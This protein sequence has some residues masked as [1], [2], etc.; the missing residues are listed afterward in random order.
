ML[1]AGQYKDK[2]VKLIVRKKSNPKEF[3]KYVDKL[4]DAGVFDLKVLR[5]FHSMRVKNLIL[6]NQ[7]IPSILSRYLDESETDIDKNAV[8]EI[9][10]NIY[11]EACEVV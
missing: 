7:K 8:K 4:M 1:D 11:K 9:I 5:I 10:R 6:N 3:E 2:I